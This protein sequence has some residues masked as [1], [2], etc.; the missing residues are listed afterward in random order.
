MPRGARPGR[1]GTGAS[2]LVIFAVSVGL[3]FQQPATVR[4]G[5]VEAVYWKG[6][7][8]AA[9]ALAEF[10]DRA[11][12]W[13]GMPALDSAP[14]RLIV[15]RSA[16]RFDSVTRGRL[17]SWS[18]GAAFPRSNTVVIM[19]GGDPFGTL[20]HELAHL[21]LHRAAAR[22]PLWFAEGYAARAAQEW[23]RLDALGLN[24][25]LMTG[26]IPSFGRLNAEL[27]SGPTHAR[28]AYALATAA[29]LF[30]ERLGRERGLG[31][32]IANAGATGSFERAVRRTH[33]VTLDQLEA[34]WHRDIRARYGWLR[35]FTSFA[36]FWSVTAVVVGVVWARRRSRDRDRKALLDEGWVIP[37][38]EPQNPA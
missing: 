35:I 16:E 38:E 25:A 26:D 17:P 37:P 11:G 3:S 27:R 34:I 31:P 22:L 7:E 12:P 32:L 19:L 9:T 36:L 10:A 30:L 1:P 23:G 14:I 2:S 13:P 18:G 21:A 8:A 15:T 6:D 4:V 33:L 20:A 29:V 28:A 24:W 5:R